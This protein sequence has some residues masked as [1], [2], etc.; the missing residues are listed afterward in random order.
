MK[1]RNAIEKI[2]SEI[3]NELILC[4]IGFPSR[5]LYDIE[6]REENFYM[7]GSMGLISSIGLGLA[8][9]KPD[10]KIII[11]D[12]DGSFLMNLGAVVTIFA[13]NPAN[14]TWIVI[15]NEAYGSTG[16]QETYAKHLN[17][18]E[19]AKS[20]GITNCYNYEEIN[21][22]EV[23][24]NDHCNFICFN[25]E[26]GNSPAPIIDLT[27]IQIKERFMKKVKY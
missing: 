27:P 15:N 25:T 18:K 16:N 5:E 13:Q 23:I 11:I 14:L 26:P 8:L 3:T 1:R 4:N 10:K 20:V 21:L 6:D 19:M 7:I 9:A 24:N 12:G 17:L 2:M 22:K